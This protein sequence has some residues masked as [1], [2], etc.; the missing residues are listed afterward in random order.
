MNNMINF[1]THRRRLLD[2]RVDVSSRLGTHNGAFTRSVTSEPYDLYDAA[3]EHVDLFI[4]DRIANL[5]DRR[6]DAIDEALERLI[7]GTYGRCMDCKQP[8][9]ERRL[10]AIPDTKLCVHCQTQR[11]RG[12]PREGDSA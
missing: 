5:E 9:S 4:E 10:S 8:I 12:G 7:S 1:E 2:E 6:L 11:E 3:Q